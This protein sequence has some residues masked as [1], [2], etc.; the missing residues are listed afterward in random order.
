[1]R[2]FVP[3]YSN[4]GVQAIVLRSVENEEARATRSQSRAGPRT[5]GSEEVIEPKRLPRA[6]TTRE[7]QVSIPT[8]Y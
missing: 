7:Q 6:A 5:R 2:S 4:T 3:N 1:M 8:V